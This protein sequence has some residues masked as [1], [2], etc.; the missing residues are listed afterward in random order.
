MIM[1]VMMSAGVGSIEREDRVKRPRQ[2]NKTLT[3]AHVTSCRA[4][5][6]SLRQVNFHLDS[7]LQGLADNN[8]I[9]IDSILA[10]Y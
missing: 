7:E 9:M 5:Y 1:M 4:T 8:V 6:S 3:R 10:R 2:P